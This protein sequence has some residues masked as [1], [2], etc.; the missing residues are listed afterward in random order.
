MLPLLPKHWKVISRRDPSALLDYENCELIVRETI[1][2]SVYYPTMAAI[3][4]HR[5]LKVTLIL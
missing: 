4:V 5:L 3:T 1:E 2:G